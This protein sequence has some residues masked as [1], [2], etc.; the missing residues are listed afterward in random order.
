MI[1]TKTVLVV[2]AAFGGA[3]FGTLATHALAP[4]PALKASFVAAEK[5]EALFNAMTAAIKADG[6]KMVELG[7]GVFQFVVSDGGPNGKFILD[8]KNGNGA[9]TYGEDPHADCTLTMAAADWVALAD[10]RLKLMSA[11]MHGK[12]KIKGNQ[13]LALKLDGP[14]LQAIR[15][16]K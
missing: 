9:A 12:L 6:A 5:S 14:I 13:M 11:L 3:F 2:T 8:L 16:Q 1:E 15:Q 7:G 4:A 10:G